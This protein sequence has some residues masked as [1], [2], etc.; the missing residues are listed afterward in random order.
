MR[1][2][3]MPIEAESPEQMGYEKIRNNLSESSYTDAIL[4]D[5]DTGAGLGDLILCYGSH[6]GH[7]GLRDHIARDAAGSVREGAGLD[8]EDV[9]LTIGAAGALFIIATTLLE[10]EDELI[11]VRPNYANNIETPRAIGATIR[12]IDLVFEEGFALDIAKVRTAIS[13]KTKFI[14][15][16]HPHNPTGACLD[17]TQLEQLV[18]LAEEKD[19][20][21]LVDETYRDMVFGEQ[22]PLAAT[23]SPRVISISSLSKTYGLPGLRV[24][25]IVCR[26]AALMEE[27]LA[28]KEQIHICG[29]ILDEE[30]AFRYLLHRATH[31]ARIKVGIREKFNLVKQWMQGE[32][33]WEW[34][35]PKGGCV[36]FPRLRASRDVDMQRFYRILLERYGTYVGAGHWFEMPSHYMR[37]GFGWPSI[38]QL[39]DGLQGLSDARREASRP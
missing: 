33:A 7:E 3:R 32:E 18:R 8:R 11:V 22:L 21:L 1:Y 5:F 28:A 14:S 23:L 12:Y 39:E 27:F 19:I 38:Q 37:I 6:Q 9:L 29:P 24:G 34:V 30:L 15:V 31:F 20:R 36:C 26:D 35:E 4:R 13:G 16:T 2:R 17:R 25:W 10:K